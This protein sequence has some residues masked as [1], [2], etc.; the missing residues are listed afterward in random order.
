MSPISYRAIAER[1]REQLGHITRTQLLEVGV[2]P[3]SLRTLSN[4][5]LEPVGFRTYRLAG[6]APSWRGD[7]MAACLDTGA[8]ASHR[9]AA[10]LHG[11]GA[12]LGGGVVELVTTR[13]PTRHRHPLATVHT[14]TDLPS[15]DL[16]HVGP[17]PCVGVARTFLMLA[18]LVPSVPQ[19]TIR[20]A[21]GDAAR[22]GKV[23]DAWLW[24]RLEHL[25][26][27][28]RAGVSV[29][30]EILRTRQRFGAT[31]S[32][33]EH[34]FLDLLDAAGLPLPKVQQRIGRKGSFVA[35]VDCL[36]AHLDLVIELEGYDAHRARRSEDERR[37][38]Q[39]VLA[40]KRVLVFTYED[41]A[42]DP[43]RVVADVAA[44]LVELAAA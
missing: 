8:V 34:T 1:A 11:L 26:C 43:V 36:Y 13:G 21:I 31:E 19:E 2:T 5:F 28:G 40:G 41:V 30:E 29:M 15:D 32:W 17:I 3:S 24:W 42:N 23:S 12:D 38:R 9:T 6:T 33:L 27:R 20:T 14:T 16:V 10:R 18:A 37:R 4:R 25:R 39:L 44:A 35:R 7:V 22:E